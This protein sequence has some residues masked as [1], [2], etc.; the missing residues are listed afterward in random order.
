M[1]LTQ[2]T[3]LSL[4]VASQSLMSKR[5]NDAAGQLD[6]EQFDCV[7]TGEPWREFKL[8][9]I[10]ILAGK[11]DDSGSSLADHQLGVDMGG[12][13]PGA[14]A[15]PAGNTRDGQHMRRLV[16]KRG[17]QLFEWY[18]RHLKS[19]TLTDMLSTPGSATFQ[20]G[21]NTIAQL[22]VLF[23]GKRPGYSQ[24]SPEFRQ[25]TSGPRQVSNGQYQISPGN[26]NLGRREIRPEQSKPVSA[27]LVRQ[28]RTGMRP[29][30]TYGEPSP[31]YGWSHFRSSNNNNKNYNNKN[32]KSQDAT[33]NTCVRGQKHVREN[34]L[35]HE[36]VPNIYRQF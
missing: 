15:L 26:R 28:N 16:R 12:P 4:L 18:I 36:S 30:S 35:V 23:D 27:G 3:L 34:H 6:M 25:W 2:L 20:N 22:D 33:V 7:S 11:I 14:V 29:N 17:K 31:R 32:Q 8:D 1:Y 9:A 21:R 24:R 13:N 10:K 19:K 5:F